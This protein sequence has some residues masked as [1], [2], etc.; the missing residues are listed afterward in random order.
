M[1]KGK[2]QT[3]R[4]YVISEITHPGGE[5]TFQRTDAVDAVVAIGLAARLRL[6]GIRSVIEGAISAHQKLPVVL[7]W[8]T[9]AMEWAKQAVPVAPMSLGQSKQ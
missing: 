4:L 6:R 8:Q 2:P 1:S 5:S 7:D 9:Y 3:G